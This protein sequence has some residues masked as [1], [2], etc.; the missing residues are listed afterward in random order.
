MGQSTS[1]QMQSAADFKTGSDA[2]R[3]LGAAVPL[4]VVEEILLNLP[5][6]DVVLICRLVCRDWKELVD[7]A[8]HW[9]ARCRREGFELRDASRPPNDWRQFYFL[10]KKRRNLLKNPRAEEKFNR[11]KLVENGGDGWKIEENVKSLPNETIEKMFV[12]SYGMCLKEQLIDLKKEGYSPAFM[13]HL[14]PGIKISDWY[15]PRR[16]CGSFYRIRVELLDQKNKPIRTFEPDPVYFEQWNDQEWCQMTHVF[17]LYGPGV[18]FI[19]FTHGGQDTKYWAGWY[20][21]RVINSSVEICPA[22]ER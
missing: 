13:D 4:A 7:S 3:T 19:R 15:A 8:A 1:Y 9:R 21:I 22:A 14:Q 16:D 6:K 17:K 12:T 5:A 2:C 20:G 18:R 10:S 11:W